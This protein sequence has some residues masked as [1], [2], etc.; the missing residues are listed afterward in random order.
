M[1]EMV[2][3][4]VEGTADDTVPQSQEKVME[5]GEPELDESRRRLVAKWQNEIRMDK[6]HWEPAFKQMRDDQ[7]FARGKQWVGWADD[8]YT[9]NITLRHIQQRVASLYAKN[10]K[11]VARRKP[12]LM[13]TVWDGTLG[14]VM[15]AMQSMQM[16]GQAGDVAKLQEAMTILQE[17]QQSV[18]TKK[19]MDDLA[20]TLELLYQY[21]I[22]EQNHP[23][24]VMMKLVVR[25]AVTTCVGYTKI[26]FQRI[27]EP[28]PEVEAQIADATQRL[29][30][31]ER[32][33]AEIADGQSSDMEAED[34]E[35]LRL[36]LQA[37]QQEPDAVVR[38]GL[39]FDYP[40]STSIIPDRKTR[41]LRE[42]LGAGHVTQ[43]YVLTPDEIKE[44]YGKDIGTGYRGYR[45]G[46]TEDPL[47]SPTTEAE[48]DDDTGMWNYNDPGSNNADAKNVALV[49][50]TYDKKTGLVYVTCDGY[51]D[52]LREPAVPEVYIERFFPWFPLVLNECDHPARIYPPS[53]VALIRDQQKEY[54]RLRE[55]MR[56][57][58]IANR[59][60]TIV[61][62]GMLSEADADK[63]VTRPANALI[64]LDGIQPGQSV[65]QVLQPLRLP[66]VD[67][68]LYEVNGIFEDILRTVGV[69]EAN[70]GS[71]GGGTATESSLA[72]SSRQSSLASN[73]DDL[74]DTLTMIAR[75]AGQILLAEVSAETVKET[76]G[77][78]AVWPEF[79][80]DELA[81]ELYLEIEAGSTGKP[82][83]AQE[84]SN[85]ERL[86]PLLMQI[87]GVSPELLAKEGIRRLDDRLE[88]ADI[89]DP[90]QISVMAMN[91]LA[92]NPQQQAAPGQQP[93]AQGTGPETDPTQQGPEGANNAPQ[94]EAPAGASPE[95]T[96]PQQVM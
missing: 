27:L 34:R 63:M 19:L 2:E 3:A 36:Q 56:E 71:V 79:S 54:N 48:Y 25:R 95:G 29:A 12:R 32:M 94:P 76:I 96:V 78:G 10:P 65:D 66:G 74:D 72:E 60:A 9:A 37:L 26:G 22:D 46:T 23:F 89:Y 1:D 43:E 5:R 21:N 11:A 87:P 68:N 42:F 75:A 61:A 44:I 86:A 18:Q 35:S 7:D 33:T 14:S 73:V 41:Q 31:L 91:Q 50:E 67:P 6:K 17:A 93:A 39:I 45:P 16:A 53:D 59:P 82:N 58:R 88:L 85:F 40:D 30:T 49:W 90:A 70:L 64:E 28:R 62:S 80:R 83:Q 8:R 47:V 92:G 77:P 38:E 69:Q 52:F 15:G 57:H 24:K 51:K 20:R 13:N 4:P 84:I 81:K 55:G